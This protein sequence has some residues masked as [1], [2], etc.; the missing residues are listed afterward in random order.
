MS[1]LFI[2]LDGTLINCDTSR[3]EIKAYILNH[4]KIALLNKIM[5]KRLFNLLK[6]K[7]WLSHEV[8]EINYQSCV[9]KSVLEFVEINPS[10]RK[11]IITASA[12]H[13]ATQ[14]RN[15]YFPGFELVTSSEDINLKG[16]SKLNRIIELSNGMEF[17]YIGDSKNDIPI[18]QKAKEA[19]L[20][21]KGEPKKTKKIFECIKFERVFYIQQGCP[22]D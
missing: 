18:F 1:L 12:K 16:L 3:N 4:G 9:N 10:A 17:S 22:H 20:V 2:D 19:I 8:T 15:I 11:I 7:N 21:V 6:L 14:V 5:Q 13:S